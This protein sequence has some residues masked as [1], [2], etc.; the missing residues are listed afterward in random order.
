ML[1]RVASLASNES[2]SCR[3][4]G[5]G[6]KSQS[7]VTGVAEVAREKGGDTWTRFVAYK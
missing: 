7:E 5:C 4:R 3:L 2:G 1:S 6:G